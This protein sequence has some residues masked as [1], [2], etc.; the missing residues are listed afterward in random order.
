VN[1][2]LLDTNIIS[3]Y[4]RAESP[5]PGIVQWM[6]TTDGTSQYLSVLTL[7]EI[8]KGILLLDQG[9][10]R[11]EIQQWFENDLPARFVGRI[12]TID[13]EVASSWAQFIAPL[14]KQGRPLPTI[15]SL[16]AATALAHDLTFVTRN[17]KHFAGLQVPLLNPWDL[18]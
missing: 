8:E 3:E 10:R 17:V 2:Y 9:K 4:N 11:R 12:L 15:D 7:G 6:K 16:L 5:H 1:G 14:L 13:R 18:P